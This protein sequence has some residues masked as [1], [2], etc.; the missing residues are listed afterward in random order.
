MEDAR[1]TPEG[2]GEGGRISLLGP[3]VGIRSSPPI[4]LPPSVPRTRVVAEE[5]F[6][7]SVAVDDNQ[8]LL[9]QV[10]ADVQAREQMDRLKLWLVANRP[11]TIARSAG[12][13]WIAVKFKDKGK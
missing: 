10:E 9:F 7:A 6:A 4:V 5:L 2:V 1:D 11:R 13:G 3:G 12:V 8:W